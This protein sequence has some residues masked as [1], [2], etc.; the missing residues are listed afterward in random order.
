MKITFTNYPIKFGDCR[1]FFEIKN[2]YFIPRW[3]F[4]LRSNKIQFTDIIVFLV[5]TSE[6]IKIWFIVDVDHSRFSESITVPGR[7]IFIQRKVFIQRIYKLSH[8]SIC[9]TVSLH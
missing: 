1:S 7:R 4:K 8:S 6:Q 3:L 5:V 9:K 2:I